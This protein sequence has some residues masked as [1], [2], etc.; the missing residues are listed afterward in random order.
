[1]LWVTRFICRIID[2]LPVERIGGGDGIGKWLKFARGAYEATGS[3][4]GRCFGRVMIQSVS[5]RVHPWLDWRPRGSADQKTTQNA[6]KTAPNGLKTP[7][8]GPK[9]LLGDENGPKMAETG[10]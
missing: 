1:M 5:I 7:K 6:F 4:I 9:R 8:I 2:G 3:G 10:D